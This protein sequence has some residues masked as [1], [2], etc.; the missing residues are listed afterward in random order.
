MSGISSMFS[1]SNDVGGV[2]LTVPLPGVEVKSSG[3]TSAAST[4]LTT[5]SSGLR[6]VTENTPGVTTCVGVFV[7][8]GS[9][10]DTVPGTTHLLEHMAFKTT[11]SRSHFR[12]VHEVEHIGANLVAQAG[13]EEMVYSAE[14]LGEHAPAVLEIMADTL[15]EPSFMEHEVAEQKDVIRVELEDAKM[16]TNNLCTE[17]AH[18]AAYGNTGLGCSLM[19]S[20]KA[21]GGLSSASLKAHMD[22]ILTTGNVVVSASGVD[23]KEF[24]ASVEKSFAA[25]PSGAAPATEAA[26]YTGGQ[27]AVP[28]DT[29]DGLAHVTLAFEGPSWHDAE[30]IPMCVL[31]TLM[32][33]GSSFSAGGPGKGMYSRLYTGV[34]NKHG[35]VQN[36]TAFNSCYNDSGLF[37]IYGAAEPR[38]VPNLVQ[39]LADQLKGMGKGITDEELS[40]A[41]NMTMSSVLMNL[42]SKPIILEDM[43]KQMLCYGKRLTAEEVC[44]QIEK[45]SAKDIEKVASQMLKTQLTYAAY[46]EVHALPRYDQ[47]ANFFK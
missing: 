1:A 21:L 8:S 28:A 40:R 16:N 10:N 14:T 36:A 31:H 2:P 20:E 3:S 32:G 26:K 19:A 24:V 15:L 22:T 38:N 11:P 47:V 27:Y 39:V 6:V 4:E 5:L 43:G 37:G 41:K 25:L 34:L 18:M 17:A 13:R 7:G 30:L 35:W 12:T 23:H 9:R 45:V 46:G 33:G 29:F 44:S 42:E